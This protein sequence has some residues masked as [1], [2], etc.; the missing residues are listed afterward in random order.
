M[1][2]KQLPV[3]SGFFG[4]LFAGWRLGKR[5]WAG[6]R[7]F[8]ATP[9][10]HRRIVFY[11]ETEAD[12]AFLGPVCRALETSGERVLKITS[13]AADGV[14]DQPDSF[15]VGFGSART[16]LFKSIDTEAFVMTLSDLQ[17]FHLKRSVHPVHYFYIFH[18]I[19]STHRV[20][21]EHAFDAYDTILCVGPHHQEEIRKTEEAYGLKAKRLVPHGY[22][23]LDTLIDDISA[24]A[25]SADGGSEE[26]NVLV[27]PSW[28]ECS[29]VMHCLDRVI[30]SLLNGPFTVTI[31]LHPMT[32]RQDPGLPDRLLAEYGP[33]ARF[34]FDPHINTTESLLAA[35][36]M[37]S[38]W[39][40]APLEYAFAR[41]RPVIFIDTPPKIHN[42]AWE[43]VD[44]P[45]LEVDIREEIGQ[46]VSLDAIETLPTVVSDLIGE[47]DDWANRIRRV[48]EETVYNLGCSGEVGAGIILETLDL[49]S[50]S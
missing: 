29:I 7:A 27:A 8:N 23:R 28:G 5:G 38:E 25:E 22:G 44:C 32:R 26:L 31:R 3:P 40:G 13:D 19:A 10:S 14:L 39:S 35:D 12:W 37:I 18:S 33:T 21:R 34:Q 17:T 20:Y 47:V 1:G 49:E 11:A 43:Q 42:P 48:R 50:R 6:L 15:F 4:R 30:R 36:I 9:K 24:Q 2:S 45:L 46:V 16:A 41:L